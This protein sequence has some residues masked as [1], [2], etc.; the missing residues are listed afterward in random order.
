VIR[1]AWLATRVVHASRI[2]HHSSYQLAFL[3]PGI[4]PDSASSLK[5]MRQ[6]PK[7][8]R[9]AFER[10]QRE[11]RFLTRPLNFGFRFARSISDFGGI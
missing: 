3:T 10:P 1:D 5:Q 8:R 6:R 7:R 4:I 2:T 11:Q 9:Y